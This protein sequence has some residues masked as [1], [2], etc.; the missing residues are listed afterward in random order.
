MIPGANFWFINPNGIIFGNNAVLPTTGSFHASTADYIKLSDGNTFAATPSPNEVLTGSSAKRVWFLSANP[1]GI[2]VVNGVFQNL[3]TNIMRVPPGLTLSLV[4]GTIDVGTGN[5]AQPQGF[6]LAPAGR[7]NLASVAS[8]GEATFDPTKINGPLNTGPDSFKTREI[9][10]DN[11]T[12]LGD[13]NIR[14]GATGPGD[15]AT[16]VVD[17]KEIFIRSGNLTVDNSLVFP[18]VWNEA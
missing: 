6:L 15:P 1:A 2:Q 18:G 7:V 16:S 4:G 8:A 3:A 5:S 17:A 12:R 11:F 10:V 9:N 13:I 14:G